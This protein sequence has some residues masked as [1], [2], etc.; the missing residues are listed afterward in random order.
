MMI[1][2]DLKMYQLIRLRVRKFFKHCV[3]TYRITKLA[4]ILINTKFLHYNI[5]RQLIS[6]FLSVKRNPRIKI[7]YH[8][9]I[10][11]KLTI[12]NEMAPI[13]ISIEE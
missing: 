2:K 1:S 9:L 12:S 3:L 7:Y 11:W 8:V 10:F 6:L 4:L 13:E 5:F